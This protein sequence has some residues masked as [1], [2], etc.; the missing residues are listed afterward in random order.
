MMAA[1][2][3]PRPTLPILALGPTAVHFFAAQGQAF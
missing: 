1:T 3:T 2:S